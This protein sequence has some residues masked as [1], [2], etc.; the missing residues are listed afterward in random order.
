MKICVISDTHASSLNDLPDKLVKK[1]EEA[2][3]IIH[4]GDFTEKKLLDELRALNEIKAVCGN[5]DSNEIRQILPPKDLFVVNGKSI[6]LT[7]GTGSR[8]GIAERVRQMFEAPDIIIYGH[9]HKPENV[10][11]DNTLMLNPGSARSSLA[12][13]EIR[14]EIQAEILRI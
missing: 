1:L 7:H 12:W 11:I 10:I 3:L 4:A 9:S 8:T 2:D 5:M 14:E 6:G 13:L